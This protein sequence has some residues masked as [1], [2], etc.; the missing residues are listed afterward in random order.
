MTKKLLT[1][2]L[3]T[4]AGVYA[5]SLTGDLVKVNLADPIVRESR[6]V[7][8]SAPGISG[9]GDMSANRDVVLNYT[10][11][12]AGNPAFGTE[13]AAFSTDS[14]CG[15]AIIY[16]GS[17]ADAFEGLFCLPDVTGADLTITP[18]TDQTSAAGD[19]GGTY[20]NPTVNNDS[21]DHT[22]TT[23][24]GLD[25]GADFTA[26]ILRVA[27]GG[28]NLSAAAEDNV[29][30]GNAT[31]WQAK[32]LTDCNTGN[33]LTYTI[34]TNAFGCEVDGG[35]TNPLSLSPE[36]LTI[37]AGVVTM[38]GAA[39]TR[40]YHTIDTEASAATDDLTTIN[41]T[42]DSEHVIYALDDAR[43]VV[44]KVASGFS[45]TDFSMN[46]TKDTLELR[47]PAANTPIERNRASNAD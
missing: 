10:E 46:H 6:Q 43:T 3:L 37:S 21:H 36:A 47:C 24:S 32:A 7:N 1:L 17:V 14:T 9:G 22:T 12:L 2:V 40:T 39:N 27:R 28:T 33:Y 34:A 41:C 11:T 20:P 45:D 35:G 44:V 30:V 38:T 15:A 29:M 4:A 5:Q 42:A 8:T 13:E 16:E 26:G 25:A 19:L 23:I 31:T 18:I